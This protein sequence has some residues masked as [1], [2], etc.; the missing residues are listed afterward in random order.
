MISLII[1]FYLSAF[2]IDGGCLECIDSYCPVE[3]NVPGGSCVECIEKYCKY[4]C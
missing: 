3:C 2:G 4:E 1:C